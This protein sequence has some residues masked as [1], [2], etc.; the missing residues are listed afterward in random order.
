MSNNDIGFPISVNSGPE[1]ILYC[2][3]TWSGDREGFIASFARY[4]P[5]AMPPSDMALLPI[6]WSVVASLRE[7]NRRT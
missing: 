7:D 5:D 6:V 1:L 4:D 2:D 3:G